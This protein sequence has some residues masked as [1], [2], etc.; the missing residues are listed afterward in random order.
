MYAEFTSCLSFDGRQVLTLHF[1]SVAILG[2]IDV[3]RDPSSKRA[4]DSK[5][6]NLALA[7]SQMEYAELN[8]FKGSAKQMNIIM[9]LWGIG[10]MRMPP[11][12]ILS[13]V[14]MI[15]NRDYAGT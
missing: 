8:F 1:P 14:G 15:M 11:L 2:I 7:V 12:E 9:D 5:E 4:K 3:F 13:R 10:L 6:E